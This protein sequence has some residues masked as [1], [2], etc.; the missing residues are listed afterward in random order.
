[1]DLNKDDK[2]SK[3]EV[4]GPLKDSFSKRDKNKDSY[5]TKDELKK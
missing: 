1:M 4:K 3:E 5:L 2:L